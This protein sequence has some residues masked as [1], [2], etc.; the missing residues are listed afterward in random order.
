M[1]VAAEQ[2]SPDWVA[3]ATIVVTASTLVLA[4]ATYWLGRQAKGE[5]ALARKAEI[6]RRSELHILET[7][8]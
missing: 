6:A 4:L 2:G 1:T 3:V 8:H 5:I 7:R